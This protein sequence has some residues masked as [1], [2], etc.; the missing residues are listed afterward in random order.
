MNLDL[1]IVFLA[2]LLAALWLLTLAVSLLALWF[3]NRPAAPRRALHIALRLSVFA[4]TLTLL[5]ST[6]LRFSVSGKSTQA[7]RPEVEY[8][9]FDTR[10][11]SS[12]SSQS[13]S[14]P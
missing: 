8:H 5:G 7:S 9:H 14:P 4:L 6:L 3:A 2:P 13:S 10:W 11:F 12:P 1:I